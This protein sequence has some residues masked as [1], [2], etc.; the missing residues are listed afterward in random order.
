MTDP[1]SSIDLAPMLT[2]RSAS[3]DPDRARNVRLLHLFVV[4][5]PPFPLLFTYTDSSIF[6]VLDVICFM[7]LPVRLSLPLVI[8]IGLMIIFK[9]LCD[10]CPLLPSALVRA[11]RSLPISAPRLT[12][13]IPR[14]TPVEYPIF[15]SFYARQVDRP[16][17]AR[18]PCPTSP[19]LHPPPF[20]LPPSVPCSSSASP[21][22]ALHF[23]LHSLSLP[24]LLPLPSLL[25]P[26]PSQT[27]TNPKKETS[28]STSS[29]QALLEHA[30]LHAQHSTCMYGSG[31]GIAVSTGSTLVLL[32]APTPWYVN[33]KEQEG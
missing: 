1:R 24:T 26:F 27:K 30:P 10:V 11:S 19:S 2:L 28:S 16:P 4:S 8:V 5:L 25:F 3:D 15:R 7:V 23:P 31:A 29:L 22:P 17:T 21:V 12:S 20:R 32:C 13:L 18:I 33:A 9:A 6:S 14:S